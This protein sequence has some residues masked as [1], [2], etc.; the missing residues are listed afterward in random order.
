M[1]VYLDTSVVVPLFLEDDHSARVKTW[2]GSGRPVALSAWMMTEFSSAL[3]MQ[4]R[5]GRV[6][7]TERTEIENTFDRW[8]RGGKLL[9]FQTER[10][11]DARKLLQDHPRL[12]G[13]DALHLAIAKWNGLQMAT[14]DDVLKEAA[15]SEGLSVV[16]L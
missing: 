8:T 5:R 7:V 11:D 1:T 2:A 13:P 16:D 6:T 9:E 4:V 3:S 14:L 12:R 10:F 15:V